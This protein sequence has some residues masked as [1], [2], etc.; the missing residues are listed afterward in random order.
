MMRGRLLALAERRA[1]LSALA[2]TQRE[3]LAAL[4]ARGDSAA[5]RIDSA[6]GVAQR[7]LG[8]LRKRPLVVAAGAALLVALRPRL[9]LGWVVR[10]GAKGWSLWRAYRTAQRLWQR[11]TAVPQAP[12]APAGR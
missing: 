6:L 8:E 11:L 3:S 12:A 10:W 9:A 2:A 5:R 1:R 4:A 7:V